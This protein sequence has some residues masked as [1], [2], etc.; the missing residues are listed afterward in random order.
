MA[1]KDQLSV[2]GEL[3]KWHVCSGPK[4]VILEHFHICTI[5]AFINIFKKKI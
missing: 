3:S 2:S 1:W 5:G 4:T